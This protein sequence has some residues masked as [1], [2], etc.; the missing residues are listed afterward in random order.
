MM[1]LSKIAQAVID[2]VGGLD[3]LAAAGSVEDEYLRYAADPTPETL[4]RVVKSLRPTIMSEITRYPGPQRLLE[5]HGKRL[6]TK[7]VKTY[8]PTRPVKLRSWVTTQLHSWV[9]TVMATEMVAQHL[10]PG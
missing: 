4:G 10:K 2:A 1:P 8:D 6:A 7:A 9:A 3:T 5:V